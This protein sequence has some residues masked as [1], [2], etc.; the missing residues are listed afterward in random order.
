MSPSV[1]PSIKPQALVL[2]HVAFEDLGLLAPVL[3]H[4]GWSVGY[5]DVAVDDLDDPAIDQADLLIV[6]GG[7]IGAYETDTYPFLSTEIALLEKRLAQD[8]PTLGI[9]LGSQLMAT[10]LGARV[11]RGSG[12]EIGWSPI[13]LTEQGRASSLSPLADDGA[14]VLHW[15]GDTFD[16]PA[17]TTRLA[18]STM[19]ANQAFAHGDNG[20]A[21]QFHLEADPRRLEQWFVGHAAELSAAGI[22]I[23]DL[24]ATTAAVASR[25]GAQAMRVFGGWLDQIR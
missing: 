23:T 4:R 13:V 22:S 25:L 12:K 24:R 8:R 5:R 11:Y 14:I 7:P 15:H 18:S 21:L 3:D 17:G 16:L 19:Y 1:R 2:Y 10:A 6:L 20:L 9:C